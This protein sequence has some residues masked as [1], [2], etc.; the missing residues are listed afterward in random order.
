[1][2]IMS[3]DEYNSLTAKRNELSSRINEARLDSSIDKLKKGESGEKQCMVMPSG[4]LNG[5]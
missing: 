2:V 4:G 5:G 3:L 1:M